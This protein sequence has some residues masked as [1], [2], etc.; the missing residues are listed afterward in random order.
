MDCTQ[1]ERRL[2]VLEALV[3]LALLH[4]GISNSGRKSADNTYFIDIALPAL[5]IAIEFDGRV[6]T[7][8]PSK[9][10]TTVLK[11]NSG[12]Q[13]GSSWKDASRWSDLRHMDEV[14]G[15]GLVAIHSRWDDSL[16]LTWSPF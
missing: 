2:Q 4:A 9:R 15:A 12:R 1:R 10:C 11:R 8:T 14:S 3:L 7:E 5:K 16:S 13:R 6:S